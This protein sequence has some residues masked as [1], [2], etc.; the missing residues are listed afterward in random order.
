[1]LLTP[2]PLDLHETRSRQAQYQFPRAERL[3]NPV[4][5]LDLAFGTLLDFV[6]TE[7][8]NVV[9]GACAGSSLSEPT[10]L[11]S[12]TFLRLSFDGRIFSN[13]ASLPSYFDSNQGMKGAIAVN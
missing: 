6:G 3:H 13:R 7:L 11:Q 10:T 2:L 12:R 8:G 1:M 5:A 9:V 4:A